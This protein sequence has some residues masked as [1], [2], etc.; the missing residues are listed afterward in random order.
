VFDPE[1]VLALWGE[2][3]AL[4]ALGRNDEGIA[5]LERALGRVQRG[6]LIHALLGWAYAVAGRTAEA[7]TVL[8][9]LRQRA[10]PALVGEAWLLAALG[11][12]EA[13]WEVLGRAESERQ[14]LLLFTGMPGFDPLRADPRWT[15]LLGQLG[16]PAAAPSSG[17]VPR[18]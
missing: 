10:A 8:A 9:E 3:V 17:K 1:N 5:A 16:V 13:A 15:A 12:T 18:P 4:T 6:T 11:D 2:G 7:R 14:L